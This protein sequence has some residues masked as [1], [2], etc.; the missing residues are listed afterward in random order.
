VVFVGWM[1]GRGIYHFERSK[2]EKSDGV[3]HGRLIEI[4]WTIVPAA[5]LMVVSVPSFTL[6]YAV[7]EVVDPALTV[8]VVGHQWYW[9]F[10]YTD[11]CEEGKSF[12][13][14][15]YML[16]DERLGDGELRLLEVDNRM[17]IP[18]EKHVRVIVTSGDVL[19][20]WAVPSFGVKVDA[21]P[22][23]LNEVS[24]MVKRPGTYYG[25]CSELCGVN[26]GFMPIGVEV[27]EEE[28]FWSWWLDIRRDMEY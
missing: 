23:R 11:L 15:S 18:S 28:E 5:V 3:V 8:K 17:V 12:V 20:S 14:E 25:Q 4:I 21:C 19:H 16:P 6:L 9:T 27:L 7:E 13:Y 22:G 26:H 24:V 2:S 1:L 10:E